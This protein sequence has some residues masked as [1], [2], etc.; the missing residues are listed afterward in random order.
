V[1]FG[2]GMLVVV[3]GAAVRKVCEPVR[4]VLA[5]WRRCRV[6]LQG[7]AVRVA[8]ALWSW[9]VGAP[10]G[11]CSKVLLLE[12]C[13]CCRV[14]RGVLLQGAAVKVACA[15][16]SWYYCCRAA[17]RV[18][19]ALWSWRAGAAVGR[20]CK[21]QL[22]GDAVRVAR[23]LWSWLAGAAA[24]CKCAGYCQRAVC[25]LGTWL[26]LQGAAVRARCAP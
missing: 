25:I 13:A 23:A 26:L 18:L 17:V 1:R 20:R 19:C 21:A 5:S 6:L 4:V 14:P 22:Q 8:C 11:C 3:Q 10:A 9:L 16:W 15:L 7:A 24:W 12:W 2:A